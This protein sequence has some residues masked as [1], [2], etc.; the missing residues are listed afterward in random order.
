MSI[1]LFKTPDTGLDVYNVRTTPQRVVSYGMSN[2]VPGQ[3][4]YT[5]VEWEDLFLDI[6]GNVIQ[7]IPGRARFYQREKPAGMD[8]NIS[9]T[10]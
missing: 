6:D 7:T 2:K 10:F 9:Q 1:P 4:Y 8:S 3:P 5:E